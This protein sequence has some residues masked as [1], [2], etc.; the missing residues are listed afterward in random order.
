MNSEMRIKLLEV[1]VGQLM[2][3]DVGIHPKSISGVYE[4]R[5]EYMEGW[6]AACIASS[7]EMCELFNDIGIEVFED[8]IN[9][10]TVE[11]L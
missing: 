8:H 7:K 3:L 2:D 4:K 9:T 1:L 10:I 5:T 11:F 6:N